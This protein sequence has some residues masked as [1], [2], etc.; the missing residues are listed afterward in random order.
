MFNIILLIL[1]LFSV[2]NAFLTGQTAEAGAAVLEGAQAAVGFALEL[3]GALCLWSAII[4]LAERCGMTRRLAD[5]LRPLLRRLFPRASE[6]APLLEAL[7]E[8]LSANL[9]GLGSA[10]TPAGIRAARGMAKLGEEGLDE[11]RLLVVLNT[12]SLQLLP[13]T[14]ASVRASLG[15]ASPFDVV[16]AVWLSSLL[17]V[18]AGLGAARLLRR[19]WR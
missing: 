9:I 5:A 12:A 3:C 11:L 6:E 1:L 14:I 19:L 8:N 10:A 17:S 4:E 2:L 7:S 15:A 16:V 18:A 13:T